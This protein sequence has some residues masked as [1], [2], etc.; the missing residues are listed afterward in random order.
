MTSQNNNNNNIENQNLNN[1]KKKYS[2]IKRFINYYYRDETYQRTE[3]QIENEKFILF[4][5]PFNRWILFPSS[6]LVQICLGAFYSWSIFNKP[7]DSY[8]YNDPIKGK[9]PITYYITMSIFGITLLF[10]GPWLERNGSKKGLLQLEFILKHIVIVYIGYGI[11]SGI[12]NSFTYLSPVSTLQKW[13]PD[14]R[15]LASGVSVCGLSFGGIIFSQCLTPMLKKFNIVITFIILGCIFL[16]IILLQALIFRLPPPN[17]NIN[18]N[19]DTNVNQKEE[20][21]KEEN[22]IEILKEPDLNKMTII[23][24]ISSYEFRILYI[25]FLANG[26]CSNI[27]SSRLADFV[28]DIFYKG[29]RILFPIISEKIGRR[30]SFN[31]ILTVL[32]IIF[33][34]ITKIISEHSFGGFI[35]LIWLYSFMYGGGF[36]VVPAFLTDLFGTKNISTCH[37]LILTSWNLAGVCGGFIFTGIYDTLRNHYHYKVDNPILYNINFYW[38]SCVIMVG[39]LCSFIIPV[40]IKYRLYPSIPNQLLQFTM[41][42]RIFRIIKNK[43]NPFQLVSKEKENEEWNNYLINYNQSLNFENNNNNDINTPTSSSNSDN[44]I[45]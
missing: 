23:E 31:I 27:I 8:I 19:N 25:M 30:E 32:V 14:H 12:G 43:K 6:L 16:F 21:E 18:N 40:K 22:N 2:Y 44:K 45:I 37:A 20:K 26:V 17:Y 38:V 5:I 42:N 29:C 28:Q 4:S 35:S 39:W 15:G 10:V 3:K 11:C 9:A 7:I 34:L 24:S 13:F 41:F 1:K 36:G 33:W